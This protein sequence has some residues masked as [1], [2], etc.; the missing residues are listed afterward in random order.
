M[1]NA[2]ISTDPAGDLKIDKEESTEKV[3]G[4]VAGD[5]A[6]SSCEESEWRRFG[7]Q[8]SRLSCAVR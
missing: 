7:L 6:G 8:P 1:D 2:Y 4:A 5:G 3:D